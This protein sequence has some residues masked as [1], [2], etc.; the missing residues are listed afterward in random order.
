MHLTKHAPYST[1]ILPLTLQNSETF[2]PLTN[3]TCSHFP[4]WL[5]TGLE[6]AV[7]RA[8]NGEVYALDAFCPHLGANLGVGGKVRGTCLECPFHSWRFNGADGK[9]TDIP[10]AKKSECLH[11][12][13]NRFLNITCRLFIVLPGHCALVLAYA[14]LQIAV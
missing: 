5:F 10:G 8:V 14:V 6:L 11:C 2:K 4:H 12:C 13:S 3:K 9:C 7:F 1:R